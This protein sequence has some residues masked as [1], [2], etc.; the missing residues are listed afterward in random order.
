M[1]ISVPCKQ[2]E[3]Q[4][5]TARSLCWGLLHCPPSP[6]EPQ[7]QAALAPLHC[8]AL[9]TKWRHRLTHLSLGQLYRE[10]LGPKIVL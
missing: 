5:W 7:V 10:S 4:G 6:T 1:C 3:Q 8:P 2:P 9:A